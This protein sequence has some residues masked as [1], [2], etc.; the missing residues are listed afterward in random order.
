MKRLIYL[1][2]I[3]VAEITHYVLRGMKERNKGIIINISSDGAFAV[4]PGNVTY[5][6]AKRFIVTLTEG[7]HMELMGTGIR[8]QAVCPGFVDTDFLENNGMYVDKTRKGMFGLR[9]PGEV[10]DEA[11]KEFEKGSIV[12]VPDKAGKLAESHGGV[13]AKRCITS[14]ADDFVNKNI[15][16]N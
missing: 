13:Y 14:F 1:Q 6:A 5:A 11:M 10:V 9:Q 15:R 12:C 8:V 7:L 2:T 16:K 4:V 3:A